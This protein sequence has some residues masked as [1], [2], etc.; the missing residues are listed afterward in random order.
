M[1]VLSALLQY[2]CL[3]LIESLNCTFI[4]RVHRALKFYNHWCRNYVA[5][6]YYPGIIYGHQRVKDEGKV[7]PVL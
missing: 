1:W 4:D 5:H 3:R 6:W 7:V 2:P